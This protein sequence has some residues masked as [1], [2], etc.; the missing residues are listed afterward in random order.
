MKQVGVTLCGLPEVDEYR[1]F[2]VCFD[3]F[4]KW[5]EVKPIMDKIALTIAQFLYDM[6]CR[7][8]CFMIQI[9]DQG[10]ELVNEV[11][12]ELHLFT[13]VQQRVTSVYHPQ[14]NGFVERQNRTMKN[15]LVKVLEENPFK[16]P[17]IIEG[18][19]FAH[20][21]S[22]HSSA[23]YYREPVLPIDLK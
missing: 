21:V 22:K 13:G 3:Y 19:L 2:I 23:K 4:R 7:H 12:D 11:S 15:S 1:Y 6:M 9:N 8:G 16:W 20:R 18:V 14:F 10:R 17:S 5:S